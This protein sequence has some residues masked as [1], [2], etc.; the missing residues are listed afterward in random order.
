MSGSLLDF[1]PDGADGG[2]VMTRAGVGY[3]AMVAAGVSAGAL[4]YAVIWSYEPEAPPPIV[5]PAPPAPPIASAPPVKEPEAPPPVAN[6]PSKIV[7]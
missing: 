3:V 1:A 7:H 5:I 4:S 6:A 2:I